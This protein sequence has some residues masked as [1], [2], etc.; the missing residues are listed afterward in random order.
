M[1]NYRLTE[2]GVERIENG[3]STFILNDPRHPAWREFESWRALGNQ[4]LELPERLTRLK[5]LWIIGAGGYGRELYS[6]AMSARSNGLEW[7][8]AGF[9]NDIPDSLDGF[10]GLPPI[11]GNTDYQPLEDDLFICAIGDVAG[12][13]AVC[14]KFKAR[15]ARF[16]SIIQESAA[17]SASAILGE[18]TI[19]EAFAGI[20]ANTRIGDFTS[21]LSH[22][23]IGHD[24]TMGRFVQVSPFAAV[25]G[26]AEIG[27]EVLIG[28]HA[29]V[30]PKVK[31]GAGATVG[32][33]S[34]VVKDVPEGATV[35]GVPAVQIQ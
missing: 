18:G 5:K 7:R 14:E 1:I 15:G 16:A 28:S 17:Y 23:G 32:A 31:V 11:A 12:R 6:M 21:I 2:S 22:T 4:P 27:D 25:L 20:G 30:L 35:F 13:K 10:P 34:V 33:G 8:V 26:W 24:V 19:V 3:H 29:V 9:L